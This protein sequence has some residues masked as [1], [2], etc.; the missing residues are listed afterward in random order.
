MS[1]VLQAAVLPWHLWRFVVHE[2]WKKSPKRFVPCLRNVTLLPLLGA[3]EED[4]LVNGSKPMESRHEDYQR[5]CRRRCCQA[6]FN[7]QRLGWGGNEV[8]W[9]D[10]HLKTWLVCVVVN[11]V[12]FL[13]TPYSVM[14]SRCGRSMS[15]EWS[16]Y[17]SS[18]GQYTVNSQTVSIETYQ[19]NAK[20]SPRVQTQCRRIG[21]GRILT[22]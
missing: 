18:D 2:S 1:L 14:S 20:D 7:N 22:I 16:A 21:K 3:Y 13:T 8:S 10:W 19:I 9:N 11:L 5:I 17:W 6:L 4:Q 15:N 12:L